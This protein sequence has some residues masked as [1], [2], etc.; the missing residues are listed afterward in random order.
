MVVER[1]FNLV[2]CKPVHGK[3]TM[4]AI[5]FEDAADGLALQEV[6]GRSNKEYILKLERATE[7]VWLRSPYSLQFKGFRILH[8]LL[9]RVIWM[10]P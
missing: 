7:K 8:F 3:K 9:T 4:K 2:L 6:V 1:R 5:E 10:W